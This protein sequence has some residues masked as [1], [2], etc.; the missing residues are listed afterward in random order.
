MID[1][2]LQKELLEQLAASY[3]ERNREILKNDDADEKKK[4]T[5]L[6]YLQ[7]H[8][9]VDAGLKQSLSGDYGFFG[10]KITAKG[11]DFLADDGGLTAVLGL[12]TVKLH[13]DTIRDLLESK[14][15]TSTLP[16]EEK[17]RLSKNLGAIGSEAL[18]VITKNLVE[19]GIES[20]PNAAH[21]LQTML[22]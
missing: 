14:I 21:W 16:L 6:L 17:K 11:L 9:L 18:K 4:I 5:N 20:L 2:A 1:R 19:K 12:V 7:E 13:A 15:S 3:P 22:P 10:S 8:E